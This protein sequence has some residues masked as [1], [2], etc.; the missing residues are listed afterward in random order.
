MGLRPSHLVFLSRQIL[1]ANEVLGRLC[2]GIGEPAVEALMAFCYAAARVLCILP[3][4]ASVEGL[5]SDVSHLSI[6]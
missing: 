1:Q 5:L 2:S 6:S 3:D 4:D